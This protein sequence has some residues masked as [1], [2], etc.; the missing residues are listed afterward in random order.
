VKAD[1]KLE[2]PNDLRATVSITLTLQQWVELR[3]SMKDLPYYGGAQ[4]LRE[5]VYQL[6][7]KACTAYGYEPEKEGEE[8]G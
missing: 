6:V 7:D 2:K 5:A 3:D 1:I 4:A 8:N